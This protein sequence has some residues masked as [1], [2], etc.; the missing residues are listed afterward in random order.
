MGGLFI[1]ASGT[2]ETIGDIRNIQAGSS[3]PTQ[4]SVFIQTLNGSEQFRSKC[5]QCALTR[6]T[7]PHSLISL[8]FLI[9]LFILVSKIIL[10]IK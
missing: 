1:I 3:P 7:S 8:H 6:S 2:N 5:M 9:L 10:I 4:Y